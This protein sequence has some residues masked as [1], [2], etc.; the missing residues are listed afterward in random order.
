MSF[1]GGC[2][3]NYD[4]YH[5][6]ATYCSPFS[7][8]YI[9]YQESHTPVRC[10]LPWKVAHHL[11]G[12][13]TLSYVS[14]DARKNGVDICGAVD[15]AVLQR[16]WN[17]QSY[18]MI[19]RLYK[20]ITHIIWHKSIKWMKERLSLTVTIDSIWSTEYHSQTLGNFLLKS[21]LGKPISLA[22][23]FYSVWKIAFIQIINFVVSINLHQTN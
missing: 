6:L 10:C 22:T 7:I 12:C 17:W 23:H 19:R 13:E 4:C 15:N 9:F 8:K 20:L 14:D 18:V 16:N 1:V 21:C 3:K 5:N 2:V 11:F